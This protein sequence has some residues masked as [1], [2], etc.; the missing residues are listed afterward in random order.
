[1]VDVEVTMTGNGTT[2]QNGTA[3]PLNWRADT[4]EVSV[5]LDTGGSTTGASVQATL[6][7]V[8]TDA[9]PVWFT[10]QTNVTADTFFKL[11][12]GPYRALRLVLNASGTD[13]WTMR[14]LQN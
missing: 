3:I 1:M 14:V 2:T 10:V 13:T 8:W 4:F 5:Y 7:N 9:S 12:G 11:N 6:D